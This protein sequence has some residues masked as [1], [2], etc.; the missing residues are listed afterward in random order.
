MRKLTLLNAQELVGWRRWLSAYSLHRDEVERPRSLNKALGEEVW[1]LKLFWR[2]IGRAELSLRL[3][4]LSVLLKRF[5][6]QLQRCDLTNSTWR[7]L[8]PWAKKVAR[9][10][11]SCESLCLLCT[12]LK[13]H[14]LEHYAFKISAGFIARNCVLFVFVGDCELHVLHFVEL[15]FKRKCWGYWLIGSFFNGLCSSSF[16]NFNFERLVRMVGAFLELFTAQS[17][18]MTRVDFQRNLALSMYDCRHCS[19]IFNYDMSFAVSFWSSYDLI[20]SSLELLRPA[21]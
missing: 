8:D 10:L 1:V 18:K 7:G 2:R 21:N 20:F 13:R 3:A 5:L 4:I 16:A 9:S 19:V 11:I 17:V 6:R 14:R 15:L 12:F